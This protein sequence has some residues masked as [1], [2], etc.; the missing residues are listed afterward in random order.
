MRTVGG[1]DSGRDPFASLNGLGKRRAEARRVLLG[2]GEETQIIG[3][4]LGKRETDESA[5]VAGHEVDG[6]GRYVLRGQGQVAF[7]LAILIVNNNDH[8][9]CSDF[10]NSAGNV[11]EG[12][13]DSA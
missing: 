11:G 3:A 7:V 10:R 5:A 9:A 8:P 6:F 4:L 1:G 2:H 12:G 13:L